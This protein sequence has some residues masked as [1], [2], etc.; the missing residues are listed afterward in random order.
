MTLRVAGSVPPKVPC[1]LHVPPR[2]HPPPAAPQ[3]QEGDEDEEAAEAEAEAVAKE[4]KRKVLK[5]P[6]YK[7]PPLPKPRPRAGEGAGGGAKAA[8]PR[9]QRPSIGPEDF[10]VGRRTVRESTRMKVEEGELERKMAEKVGR[11]GWW[12]GWV[13]GWA[14]GGQCDGEASAAA[15]RGVHGSRP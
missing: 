3:E 7:K 4:P 11:G 5:P 14:G 15:W 12:V 2:P 8:K 1:P 9:Q 13:G 10:S 6:G